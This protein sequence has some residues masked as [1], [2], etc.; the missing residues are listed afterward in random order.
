MKVK[1][2]QHISRFTDKGPNAGKR[3]SRTIRDFFKKPVFKRGNAGW[4]RELPSV[5]KQYN[6]TVQSSTKM[7]PVQ[8]SGNVSKKEV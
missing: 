1:K 4:L 6:N 2:I 7:T 8:A 3:V 5:I